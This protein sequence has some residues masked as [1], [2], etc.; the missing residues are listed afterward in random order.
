MLTQMSE[1][2][3][4]SGKTD[5]EVG[6]EASYDDVIDFE[7]DAPTVVDWSAPIPPLGTQVF[8]KGKIYKSIQE[9]EPFAND[10]FRNPTGEWGGYWEEVGDTELVT[11][12]DFELVAPK[13]VD[14]SAPIPP[15]GTRVFYKGGVYSSIQEVEPFAND[16]NRNPEGAWGGYWE[17]VGETSKVTAYVEFIDFELVAPK[18]I[19][20][21]DPIPPI[22]TLVF[23]R[24]KIYA[25]IQEVE[26]FANDGFRN[27]TGEWGGYWEEIGDTDLVTAAEPEK[28]VD[29]NWVDPLWDWEAKEY[30]GT[31]AADFSWWVNKG[32]VV[33]YKDALYVAKDGLTLDNGWDLATN[34][35]FQLTQDDFIDFE[36]IAV[37]DVNDTENGILLDKGIFAYYKGSVFVYSGHPEVITNDGFRNPNGGW[38]GYWV[39]VGKTNVVTEKPP[40]D[41]IFEFIEDTFG[42]ILD[43]SNTS[44]SDIAKLADIKALDLAQLELT[45]T[46]ALQYFP[47]LTWLNLN[48]NN[49]T[50]IDL[51]GLTKLEYLYLLD[52]NISSIDVTGLTNLKTLVVAHNPITT[53][54]TSKNTKLEKLY[55]CHTKISSYSLSNNTA[56]TS[57]YVNGTALKSLD[58]TKLSNLTRINVRDTGLKTLNTSAQKSGFV[59]AYGLPSVNPYTGIVAIPA[60]IVALAASGVVIT[61]K[62][63]RA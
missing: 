45:D 17:K 18:A 47:N 48:R 27:P 49:L 29:P 1:G 53:L 11:A 14:W 55:T 16:G 60:A 36:M 5:G 20:W 10:G 28:P 6:V 33:V 40:R 41:A 59:A 24:G 50:S 42:V 4:L 46:S 30:T 32:Q 3:G 39:E 8:Y 15:I 52:N 44:P 61:R 13:A 26:P 57:L 23:Y 9:I 21:A 12:L 63:K 7:L 25:S 38:A 31:N 34:E 58:I 43:D 54:D 19:N 51:S 35:N 56:L 2:L 37:K 62:R 22:G